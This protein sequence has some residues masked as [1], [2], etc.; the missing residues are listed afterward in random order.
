MRNPISSTY[1]YEII[2]LPPLGLEVIVFSLDKLQIIS[3]GCFDLK[4]LHYNR[5]K[6]YWDYVNAGKPHK[7]QY[8]FPNK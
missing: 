5:F 7:L 3:L 4:L 1:G 6:N 8:F 2:K